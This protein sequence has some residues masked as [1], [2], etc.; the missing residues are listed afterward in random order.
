MNQTAADSGQIN[1]NFTPPQANGISALDDR[2][3]DKEVIEDLRH[4]YGEA[5]L[6][7]ARV[8]IEAEYLIAL[9]EQEEVPFELTN[10]DKEE[11]R[12]I[13][14]DFDGDD[15]ELIKQIELDG[16]QV[17]DMPDGPWKQQ[18]QERGK[19]ELPATYHDVKAAEYFLDA[20]EPTDSSNWVHF[21]LT[22]EDANNLAYSWLIRDSFEQVVFPSMEK[23]GNKYAEVADRYKDQPMLART[24][25]Q[26]ATPTTFGKE[27][28][29]FLRRFGQQYKKVKNNVEEITGKLAGAT[30][31]LNAHY[32]AFEDQID[33]EQFSENFVSNRLDLE[34]ISPT[35]QINPRDQLSN[36]LNAVKQLNNIVKDSD[37]DFWRY[38]SDGLLVKERGKKKEGDEEGEGDG[39]SVGS[40]T[41]P[42][43]VNP[44]NFENA[45]GNT[46]V[47][48]S[49]I[50]FLTSEITT[51]RGQRDLSGSTVKRNYGMP[52]GHTLLGYEKTKKGLDRF[53]VS[54]DMVQ[55]L[56]DHPEVV[57]EAWQTLMRK[58]N[59]RGAYEIVK[60]EI[61]GKKNL[62]MEDLHHVVDKVSQEADL[63][64]QQVERLK[65]FKPTNYLGDCVGKAER[66]L[67]KFGDLF[68]YESD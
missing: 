65:Q 15:Y 45:E 30:G 61:K 32:A 4:F 26:P 16:W 24:H 11:L 31:G 55:Q 33:W 21:G 6:Q 52:L 19:E 53:V 50:D 39:G 49:W 43:K 17:E 12:E 2:Y 40:S 35:T 38:I 28:A 3:A 47:A 63:S 66:A 13:Y 68:G 14:Q 41:M 36:A 10:D 44:I 22:S 56:V 9:S 27:V 60:D 18:W 46:A 29:V 51:S 34:Y 1:A 58:W 57:T 8:F 48:N 54:E 59:V 67:E 37:R 62:K 23:L 42:Q 64:E 7:N 5:P 20:M 25:G